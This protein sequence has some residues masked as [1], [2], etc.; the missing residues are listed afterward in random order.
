MDSK[1]LEKHKVEVKPT[2]KERNTYHRK[3]VRLNKAMQ[4]RRRYRS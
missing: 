3:K 2:N 1:S 4:L